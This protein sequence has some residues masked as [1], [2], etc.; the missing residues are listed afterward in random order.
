M[1]IC[2]CRLPRLHWVYHITL[3]YVILYYIIRENTSASS[4][5][6]HDC[7]TLHYI[8]LYYIIRENTSGRRAA[9]PALGSCWSRAGGR[10]ACWPMYV[11]IIIILLLYILYYIYIY[12]T[13][14]ACW[15]A[16]GSPC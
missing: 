13:Y 8:R 14:A 3:H 4:L 7:I 5:V 11:Y 15:P 6:S 16:A 9:P 10:A 1:R 12:I 2:M